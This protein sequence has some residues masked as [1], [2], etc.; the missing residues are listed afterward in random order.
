MLKIMERRI[1]MS[2]KNIN[3]NKNYNKKLFVNK[4]IVT[5]LITI[6]AI[7]TVLPTI[8]SASPESWWNPGWNYR[9]LLT[10]DTSKIVWDVGELSDSGAVD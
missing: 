2:L 10:L 4:I 7:G 8:H 1:I 6:L 5:Y 3:K 9:K